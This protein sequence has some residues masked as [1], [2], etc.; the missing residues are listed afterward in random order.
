[1]FKSMKPVLNLRDWL[2]AYAQ[3]INEGSSVQAAKKKADKQAIQVKDIAKQLSF[4]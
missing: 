1:M 2:N 3:S 4:E